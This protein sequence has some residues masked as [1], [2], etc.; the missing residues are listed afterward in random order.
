[1]R[2]RLANSSFTLGRLVNNENFVKDGQ[3]AGANVGMTASHILNH[4]LLHLLVKHGDHQPG[5]LLGELQILVKSG[6]NLNSRQAMGLGKFHDTLLLVILHFDGNIGDR[7]LRGEISLIHCQC[8]Q[9][10]LLC[11]LIVTF[12]C[13]LL[14][15]LSW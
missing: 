9:F 14:K 8:C 1:M 12:S 3:E 11:L 15:A 5:R 6:L 4:S 10:L 7:S 2:M 13:I